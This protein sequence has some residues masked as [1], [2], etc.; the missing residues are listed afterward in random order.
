MT[1]TLTP[2]A[3]ELNDIQ[4]QILDE[5]ERFSR[6]QLLPLAQKMDDTEE[7]P[8]DLFDLFARH[9]YLGI[10]MPEE[11]GGQGLGLFEQGLICQAIGK[12]NASAMLTWGAHDN[13]CGNNILRNANEDIKQHLRARE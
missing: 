10:T 13:L 9:G 4:Q 3:F 11:Y 8:D 1:S 12:Y 2:G 7:C 5:A 6:E